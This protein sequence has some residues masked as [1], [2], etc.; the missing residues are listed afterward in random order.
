MEPE[1]TGIGD[2]SPQTIWQSQLHF[3]AMI[4]NLFVGIW[5]I[6]KRWQKSTGR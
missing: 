3:V 4:L 2:M 5:K 1:G 6:C